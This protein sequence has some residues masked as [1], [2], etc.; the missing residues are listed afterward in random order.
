MDDSL[1]RIDEWITD[2]SG[3]N[4]VWFVKRLAGNDTALTGS[5][6]GGPYLPKFAAFGL[7]PSVAKSV[8]PRRVPGS[9]ARTSS[10]LLVDGS[11]EGRVHEALDHGSAHPARQGDEQVEMFIMLGLRY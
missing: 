10:S 1:E 3:T 8:Q 2:V 4:W 9:P 11:I 6:Q 5:H 7:F